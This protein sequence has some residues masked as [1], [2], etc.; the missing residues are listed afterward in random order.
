MTLGAVLGISTTVVDADSVR[1]AAPY[2]GKY[3]KEHAD[4][5]AALRD[6]GI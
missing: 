4:V 5:L 2:A 3:A 6:A 1:V